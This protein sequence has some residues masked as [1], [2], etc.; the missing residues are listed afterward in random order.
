MVP[1]KAP[2]PKPLEPCP[3]MSTSFTTEMVKRAIDR[4]KTRRAYDHDGLV[5]EHFIHARDMLGE[6]LAVML[7][8]VMYKGL[9]KT[10]RR[11]YCAY[12][13]GK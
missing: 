11:Y 8:R 3:L 10:W 12:L 6:V 7:N 1:G 2:L 4:M 9:L 13:Q 5:A